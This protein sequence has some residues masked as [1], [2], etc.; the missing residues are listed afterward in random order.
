[1]PLS[2]STFKSSNSASLAATAGGD[3]VTKNIIKPGV[4]SG[5]PAQEHQKQLKM[6]AKIRK[7][8]N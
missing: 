2:R 6:E 8:I 5:F 4:Y 7:V 3:S 1:M